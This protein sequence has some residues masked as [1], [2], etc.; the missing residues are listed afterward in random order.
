MRLLGLLPL[1]CALVLAPAD[2]RTTRSAKAKAEF[3]RENPCPSTGKHRGRC[4]GFVIDHV[5]PLCAG[6]ADRPSNM[7]WQTIADAKVKDKE[8]WK[9]CR[10]LHRRPYVRG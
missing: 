7:Q 4:P 6:G 2:A 9:H 5:E 8:E 10:A 3:Q 1:A